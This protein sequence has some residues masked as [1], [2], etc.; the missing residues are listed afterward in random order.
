[1]DRLIL[2]TV[3]LGTKYGINNSDGQPKSNESLNILEKAFSLGIR[4]LDTAE[5]YGDA[6]KVIKKYHKKF[7]LK[8][9]NI[10]DKS[11]YEEPKSFKNKIINKLELL[12]IDNF[13]GYMFH[14]LDI[15]KKNQA[16]YDEIVNIKKQG[17]IKNL[18][19][20]IY[21]DEQINEAL[22]SNFDFDFIQMP[23]N[24]LDNHNL[25][26]D[27]IN[28]LNEQNIEIHVRSI[29]LQGLFYMDE[30]SLPKKLLPLKK[31]I[32]KIKKLCTESGCSIDELLM[33]YPKQKKYVSK[34]IF[35]V[36]NINHLTKNIASY[37]K[38]LKISMNIIDEIQVKNKKLLN[39]SIW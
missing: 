15:F 37:N 2:G 39:P 14:S 22:R 25:R 9:F 17:L 10:F 5:V 20:S 38:E 19:I 23:F 35:G 18:G 3:Q 7:P 21:T 33:H 12:N 31:Y 34:I 1:M 36:D 16:I 24:V 27:A 26:K 13:E 4:N 32:L 28:R 6:Y 30:N 11:S 8:K 29:F